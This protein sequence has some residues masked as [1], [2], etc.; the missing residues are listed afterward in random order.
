VDAEDRC[1]WERCRQEAV[2]TYFGVGL[3]ERHWH[4]VCEL[5]DAGRDAQVRDAIRVGPRVATALY[6]GGT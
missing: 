6:A 3:C 5:L 2:M 1:G 4:E